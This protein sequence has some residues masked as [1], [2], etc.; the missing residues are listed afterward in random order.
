MENRRSTGALGFG[1][2]LQVQHFKERLAMRHF[3]AS[4]T[5]VQREARYAPLCSVKHRSSKRGSLCAT[6]YRQAP[7]QHRQHDTEYHGSGHNRK[8]NI[9]DTP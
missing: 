3:V 1:G 2:S 7:K 4:S 5:E 6:L 9:L 8:S